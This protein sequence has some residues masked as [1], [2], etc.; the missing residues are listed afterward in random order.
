MNKVNRLSELIEFA[1]HTARLRT[2]PVADIARHGVFLEYE[3]GIA[4]LPG[5]RFDESLG[6]GGNEVWLVVE[7]LQE[8]PAPQPTSELLK[9]WLE[10]TNNPAKEPALRSHVEVQTLLAIG[11]MAAPKDKKDFDPKQLVALASFG[12]KQGVEDHFKA[13]MGNVWEP[14]A[15]EEK[16]RRRA[17]SLYAKLFTL[18][19]QLEG[20]IV[21]TPL[22]L[23]WGV[24]LA[25][26]NMVG[27]QVTYPIITRLVDLSLNDKTMAIEIRPRDVDPRV[28]LDI[29]SAAN[30]PG[31]A[32]LE[33]A[34]KEFF[35]KAITTFSPFDLSTF[36][37]LLR[38]AVTHLDP[39]GVYWPTQTTAEDRSLPKAGE[40]I[41]VT[42]TWVLFA[43][44][45]SNSLFIQDLERFKQ[46][47]E[48]SE[49]AV[50]PQ[51]VAALVTE[52][53]TV[54]VDIS[55]PAFR[56][57]SM[58]HGS[59]DMGGTGGRAPQDLFFPL[60]FNDEQARIVQL[61]ECYDG[62]V[63]Q[64]PPGTGK[65]HTI[66]NIICH[67]L[68]L[69]KRVLVTSMKEP[70]LAVLQE[71][72]PEEIRPLAISL[73]T[74]EQEGMKQFENAVSKIASE[75]QRID[76][77]SLSR[78]ISQIEGTIDAYHARLAK[79]DSQIGGWATKNLS[80]IDLDGEVFEPP[81][82][83]EQVIAND[84]EIAWFEDPISIGPEFCPRFT[85]TDIIRLRE[86]RRVLAKDLDY[87]DCSL[88]L[89]SSFPDAQELLRVHQ[90][91]SRFAKLQAQVDSGEVPPLVDSS[92]AA[93]EAAH[94]LFTQISNLKLQRQAIRNVGASWTNAMSERLR[95][96]NGNEM[97][98]VSCPSCRV[99]NRL[100]RHSGNG[101]HR[102]GECSGEIPSPFPSDPTDE[103]IT[104]LESVGADLQLA[105]AERQ[106]FLAKPVTVPE[107]IDQNAELVEGINNLTQG[108]RP[109]GL[110]GL[111][112]KGAGKKALESIRIVS[113]TASEREDWQH[114]L[115]YVFHLK[116]QR[117]LVVRWNIIGGELRLPTFPAEPSQAPL[118]AEAFRL[119]RKLQEV[120][121]LEASV[122]AETKRVFPMWAKGDLLRDNDA[123][124]DEV[125]RILRHHLTR[126]RLSATWALKERF[127][128]V[129][130]GCSG[131]ITNDIH[132]FLDDFLGNPK[133]PDAKIQGYWSALQ[134]EVRRVHGLKSHLNTVEEVS[135]VIG[136]SGAPRW[137]SRLRSE[138]MTA[139]TDALLP[140]SWRQAWRLKRL[141]TY[142]HAIDGRAEL[143]NLTKLRVEIEA[144]LARAYQQA[145]TK[146]TWL[147]LAENATPDVRSAL[148]AY[149][150]AIARIGR[151]GT[152]IRAVRY[153]QDAR[154][155]AARA[156]PAIPCWIMPH[157][158]V[159]ES[160]PSAFGC[161][162]LVVIDEAS[163]SDLTALPAILRAQKILVV[164]DDKQVSPE[165]VGLEEQKV[166]NLMARFLANQ[167]ETYRPQ[168]SPERS[169]YDLFK[170]VFAQSA[171]ML[172]EHF[173]CVA[174]IIEYS[175]REFYNHELK[176]LRLPKISERLDPPLVDVI[177]EDGFRKGDINPAEVRFIVAEIKAIVHDPRMSERSI[178]V[179]SL[180]GDKQALKV[181]ETLEEEI[182][183]DL[184]QRHRV[185]CGDARTF[186]GKE[187]DIMFLSM[188][189]SHN[190]CKAIA[191]AMFEQ[192]FNV[193]ASRAKDR[194]YLV[195]SVTSEDLKEADRLRRGLI[196]HFMSP[197]AQDEARVEN[198]REL[199]ES[200]FERELYAI[201]A[202]R[203]YRV[204]PQVPV[205]GFRID[206]VV[207]GHQDNR[208]AIECDGDRY[209]G[210]DHWEDDMR[211]Q[212][213]LERAG[214]RFWRCF[215][216]TFVMRR[217]EVIEDL[218]RTLQERG[219]EPIGAEGAIHSL[220]VEQRRYIAFPV[221]ATNEELETSAPA[222]GDLFSLFE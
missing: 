38:S 205:G 188:V 177:V 114:V 95:I 54:N 61:L 121:K 45:R 168:M 97:M 100:R 143:K 138:P 87:L 178:G 58:V 139:T 206:M 122:V 28:E 193:A 88:P 42:D 200:P 60:P 46:K 57:V 49:M 163:Q 20:G 201:L 171:V 207:E 111:F 115:N 78:E 14:W 101:T 133:V 217:Q 3:H 86:A 196:A 183:L 52:P 149:M 173:R 109:F 219:I 67:Y 43:R 55:L 96:R 98:I 7:R 164:G 154:D 27:T 66:A 180:L 176:P 82:A 202:E 144:D 211:R 18:K 24:G 192:R 32:G 19:Q 31:V 53:A 71:K 199:C 145:V 175:K 159:S 169:I 77:N 8:S 146:R 203:G 118:A 126:N 151:R 214:W 166:R 187:R 215:A 161:F 76:R 216:S 39:K 1:Q 2:S 35:T 65:T 13:Y 80:K 185:A 195:R 132:K 64:G 81:E 123:V 108:K 208:L 165:G 128:Q 34:A 184:I 63:V 106:Q 22:E 209:H 170:V 189:V 137:A 84:H 110:T 56:G 73:L 113:S 83:A 221:D 162:D 29:Y 17:I 158:R 107:D 167:V 69:G 104:L 141:S 124:L 182:G 70:A 136:D 130:S 222:Q 157:F 140:D 125:E 74:S 116:Q 26:W 15:A 181:W 131:R 4:G 213:I 147:K 204:L 33:K 112:G 41:R 172:K 92:K 153:R 212:R 48:D 155:A 16:R 89:V 156:N 186:Q 40:E 85:D 93:F 220:H 23:A 142:L 191:G 91:I 5:L 102:C 75:V 59:G 47:L 120:V 198:L 160:L 197:F 50:L 44:P 11:A 36:E 179:V 90:D 127:K 135:Q 103:L 210:P 218:L 21:D 30:N 25:V 10:L 12:Q 79:I 194:M 68:A 150:S 6:E 37:P 174:P 129:L 105:A 148:M 119:Y 9:A 62:V 99:K 94:H 152:G 51:T 190:D 72:L 134:E 117:E